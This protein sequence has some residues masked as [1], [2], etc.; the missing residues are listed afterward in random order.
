[1]KIL[2]INSGSSSLKSQY[3]IDK[4]SIASITIE[5]I[6]KDSSR[7]TIRYRGE[8]I[9][10]ELSIQNHKEAL[11]ILFSLLKEFEVI[12]DIDE[13]D[14][15]GHRVVHGGV[16]FCESVLIDNKVI[17]SIKSISHLAPLHNHIN[18]KAIKIIAKEYPDIPQVAVFDTAFHHTIPRYASLYAI[19]YNLSQKLSIRRYGFH[20]TS[21]HYV[22]KETAKLLQRDIGT[23]NLITLHLGNGASICAIKDGES[24]DTSMG[25]TPLEGLM[26]GERCGD[27]DSAIIPHLIKDG[28]SLKDIYEELNSSSGLKGIC[29][30]NDMREIIRLIQNGDEMA[31]LALEMYTYK[32]K[33]YIGAYIMAL[34]RVDG[35]IFTAGVGENTPIVRDMVCSG[36][37]ESIGL[38]IDKESNLTTQNGAIHHIN[39]KI[40]IFVIPTNEELEIAME[41]E[42][43]TSR[44]SKL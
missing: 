2:V 10:K 22:A 40:P 41:T 27:I 28:K 33:K 16:E 25:F 13:L 9:T 38:K 32:I 35:I 15:I 42:R 12:I 36:L 34:G 31:T 24:I 21:H 19:P 1:M 5:N 30:T 18:L 20:G 37:E 26:M 44:K 39:S 11:D 43:I 6:K 3:F 4:N 23:L 17:K 7:A 8:S 14:S 29:G